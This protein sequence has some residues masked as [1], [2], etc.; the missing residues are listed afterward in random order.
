MDL[1]EGFVNTGT[2]VSSSRQSLWMSH[3]DL[4]VDPGLCSRT[5]EAYPAA[6]E[7]EQWL[8]GGRYLFRGNRN[9]IDVQLQLTD[10]AL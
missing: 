9:P 4:P 5:G 7:A 6:S 2:A 10:V 8:V 3:D 1:S